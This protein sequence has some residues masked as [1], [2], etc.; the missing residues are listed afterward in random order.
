MKIAI[1][2]G[3]VICA[4]CGP[5]YMDL[6]QTGRFKW[7]GK[8]KTMRG[9][10]CYITMQALNGVCSLPPYAKEVYEKHKAVHDA[11]E[12]QRRAEKPELLCP[13]PVKNCELMGHQIVGVNMALLL[14]GVVGS[15]APGGHALRGADDSGIGDPSP[16]GS[17]GGADE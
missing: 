11:M 13:V 10:D 6:R 5:Y 1:S 14:F 8:T 15:G 7:D 9:D 17:V 3:K 12:E 4:E 2:D 16:T